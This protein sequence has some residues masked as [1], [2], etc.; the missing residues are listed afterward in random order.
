MRYADELMKYFHLPLRFHANN[1]NIYWVFGLVLKVSR[2]PPSFKL[3]YLLEA[4]GR[5]GIGTRP[6]FFSLHAQP[7]LK[8]YILNIDSDF[9]CSK[10]LSEF[11]FYLPSGLDI[12]EDDVDYVCKTL[13]RLA[14]DYSNA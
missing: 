10:Y 3:N 8:H 9:S 6:F 12:V 5:E 1:E 14:E 4:L 13:L 2:F 11:G 7:P